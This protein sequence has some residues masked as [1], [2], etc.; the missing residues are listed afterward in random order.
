MPHASAKDGTRLYYEEA[1]SG[2]PVVFIHEFAGDYRSW[3]PQMRCLARYFRC[4]AYNARGFPPSDVPEDGARYSQAQARDDVIA[5]LDHLRIERAHVV[6]LSRG[7]QI[8]LDFAVNAPARTRS[9]TWV[10]GGVRGLEVPDDPRDE[11]VWHQTEELEK[12]KDWEKIVELETQLWTDGPDQPPTRVDPDVRRRMMQ[13]NLESYGAEQSPNQVTPPEFVAAEHL[14]RL[15]MPV[16]A[17]WG[18]LDVTS[19]LRSGEWLVANLPGIRSRVFEGVAHMVNLERPAEFNEML[20]EPLLRRIAY[21]DAADKVR[22][23]ALWLDV[24]YPSEYQYDKL[25]GAI[26]V[27]LAEVRNMFAVLDRSKEYI[28]Y[29]QSGRR[30]AAAAFLFAQRGFK[31]WLLEG[32]LKGVQNPEI[33]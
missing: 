6:G 2:T 27:P 15:T 9:L 30:S 26:N 21:A 28:A 4:I 11:A 12:T 10:A 8:A 14:D 23:G 20:R 25:P 22:R 33:R 29:C 19:T 5:V 1:G 3:E 17:T 7:A 24:R 32:G 31:V 13:W 18:T 16:L